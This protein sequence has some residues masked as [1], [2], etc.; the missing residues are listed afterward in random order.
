MCQPHP[1]RSPGQLYPGTPLPSPQ[2]LQ[3]RVLLRARS[4]AGTLTQGRYCPRCHRGQ[5]PDPASDTGAPGSCTHTR[6]VGRGDTGLLLQ[7]GRSALGRAQS[8]DR[9][10]HHRHSPSPTLR[11]GRSGL[12]P[13]SLRGRRVRVPASP[14]PAHHGP[15]RGP[16]EAH[17]AGPPLPSAWLLG[18]VRRCAGLGAQGEPKAP[19]GG[20]GAGAR[21]LAPTCAPPAGLA[22]PGRHHRHHRRSAR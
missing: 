5:R 15:A 18:R 13:H 11:A 2:L 21:I 19:G 16:A 7:E 17:R 20:C 22:R 14:R 4:K 1:P 12:A 6:A 8:S 9:L 10:H 3:R